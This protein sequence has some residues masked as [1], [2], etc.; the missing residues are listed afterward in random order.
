MQERITFGLLLAAHL[1]VFLTSFALT[2]WGVRSVRKAH[3][4]HIPHE[5]L[6]LSELIALM[7]VFAF[8]MAIACYR[9]NLWLDGIVSGVVLAL[10]Y[11]ALLEFKGS[12]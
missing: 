6:T 2:S 8:T 11:H 1:A 7:L 3:G 9:C 12:K 10:L 5:R 4:K